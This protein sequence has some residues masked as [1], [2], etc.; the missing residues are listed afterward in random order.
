MGLVSQVNGAVVNLMHYMP[1]VIAR[2]TPPCWRQDEP[3]PGS[4]RLV[5][6]FCDPHIGGSGKS[7][8]ERAAEGYPLQMQAK[9]ITAT[10]ATTDLEDTGQ[11]SNSKHLS[12]VEALRGVAAV[13]V[14]CF[15][16]TWLPSPPLGIPGW[17][18]PLILS[19]GT[20]VA[21]F[22]VVSAFI[23]ASRGLPER[24]TPTRF[25]IFTSAEPSESYRC[26]MY[27]SH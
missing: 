3:V 17:L 21:L 1:T 26:S 2:S 12:S 22:F 20:G 6:L 10:A 25:E 8:L 7:F 15:H 18:R 4:I 5:W 19:G 23:S 9:T 27:C 24:M 16:M 13:Y 14:V 11:Q